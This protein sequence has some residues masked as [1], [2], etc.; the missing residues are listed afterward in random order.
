MGRG[1]FVEGEWVS[2][3]FQGGCCASLF[4]FIHSFCCSLWET[5]GAVLMD[6]QNND[7]T[8]LSQRNSH[9]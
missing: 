7:A 5:L 2:E 3:E 9:A 8:I 4:F 1:D 6:Y